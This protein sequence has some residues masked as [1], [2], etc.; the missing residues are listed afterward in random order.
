[1]SEIHG[2][3]CGPRLYEFEGWLFEVSAYGGPWPLKKNGDPRKRA[4]R[5]WWKVWD[6]F[7][8]LSETEK[9]KFRAGGGCI[10][11]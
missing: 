4:G 1:M 7:D 9:R 3:I 2:Y 6:R 8:S 10:Q 11:F 5:A